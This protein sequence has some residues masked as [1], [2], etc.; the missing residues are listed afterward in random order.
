MHIDNQLDAFQPTMYKFLFCFV[1][2]G[3][4]LGRCQGEKERRNPG[5][6]KKASTRGYARLPLL[7]SPLALAMVASGAL[8]LLHL[9]SIVIS[10]SSLYV[11]VYL[12]RIFFVR[13]VRSY[14]SHS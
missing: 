11:F 1:V 6:H 8:H 3:G 14:P 5:E 13:E 12:Q 4:I 2:F 9:I 7:Y 10:F